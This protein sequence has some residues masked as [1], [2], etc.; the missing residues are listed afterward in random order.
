MKISQSCLVCLAVLLLACGTTAQEPAITIRLDTDSFLFGQPV[1]AT[2]TVSNPSQTPLYL[3]GQSKSNGTFNLLL[4]AAQAFGADGKAVPLHKDYAKYVGEG[5]SFPKRALAPGESVTLSQPVPVTDVTID[6]LPPGSYQLVFS[7][8]YS[9]DATPRTWEKEAEARTVFR[10]SKPGG[11]DAEWL[12]DLKLGILKADKKDLLRP[13]RQRPLGWYEILEGPVQG[14]IPEMVNQHP[15][16][17]Y[18]GYVLWSPIRPMTTNRLECL[19]DPDKALRDYAFR[20]GTEENTLAGIRQTQEDLRAYTK[21]LGLFL[22]AHPEFPHAQDLRKRYAMCLG[23]TGRMSDALVQIATLA[24][25]TGRE[26]DEAK[27]FLE[28]RSASPGK[29]P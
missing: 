22:E 26:A 23:L 18:A 20:G 17:T 4:W 24:K 3:S 28:A 8:N 25:G 5:N 14:I 16:S 1:W 29:K 6:E 9:T 27:A 2:Y 13:D 10:I 12:N 7:L 19:N 21:P 11:E 15:T